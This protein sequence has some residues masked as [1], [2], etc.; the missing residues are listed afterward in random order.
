MKRATTMAEQAT[1][2]ATTGGGYAIAGFVYQLVNSLDYATDVYVRSSASKEGEAEA[3]TVTLEPADG[4]DAIHVGAAGKATIQFKTRR[5][6]KFTERDVLVEVLPDLFKA[7]KSDPDQDFVLQTNASVTLSGSFNRLCSLLRDDPIDEALDRAD[8][9]GLTFKAHQAKGKRPARAHLDWLLSVVSPRS[10]TADDRQALAALLARF[11]VIAGVDETAVRKRV[12]ARLRQLAKSDEEAHVL[13]KTLMGHLLNLAPSGR[14]VTVAE[15]FAA[16]RIETTDLVTTVQFVARVH[17]EFER[18]ME[19]LGYDPAHESRSNPLVAFEPHVSA[20]AGASG[21]GKTW[22]L[23]RAAVEADADGALVLWIDRPPNE[24]G[25]LQAEV[26]RRVQAARRRTMDANPLAMRAILEQAAGTGPAL[27]LCVCLDRFSSPQS[28]YELV[29]DPWL[30]DNGIE[31]IAALPAADPGAI[32]FE[33]D[34]QVVEVEPFTLTEVRRYLKQQG[35]VWTSIPVDVLRLLRTPA[36]ARQFASLDA[37]T[38][39]PSDEYVLM[40]SAWRRE[41]TGP[42]QLLRTAKAILERRIDLMVDRILK[43]EA[44][45][46]PWPA[47]AEPALAEPQIEA[48]ER[49]GFVRWTTDG[50]LQFDTD[51]VLAWGLAEALARRVKAGSVSTDE[52]E[53]LMQRWWRGEDPSAGLARHATGYAPLDLLWLLAADGASPRLMDLIKTLTPGRRALDWSDIATLGA[54]G[55]AIAAAYVQTVAPKNWPPILKPL[56]DALL[57]GDGANSEVR[58]IATRFLR[59]AS[60]EQRMLALE[61]YIRHPDS[62]QLAWLVRHRAT[63]D[64]NLPVAGASFNRDYQEREKTYRAALAATR[65][66]PAAL[67]KIASNSPSASDIRTI[68]WLISELP[69]T[70]AL[71]AWRAV[72]P[73]LTEVVKGKLVADANKHLQVL[74]DPALIAHLAEDHGDDAFLFEAQCAVE[75]DAALARFI[76]ASPAV[77]L[78]WLAHLGVLVRLRPAVVSVLIRCLRDGT[79]SSAELARRMGDWSRSSPRELWEALMA[80]A[81]QDTGRDLWRL[82][83]TM[84]ATTSAALVDALARMRDTP[85]ERQLVVKGRQHVRAHVGRSADFDLKAVSA[86]LL[87]VGGKGFASLTAARLAAA[88]DIEQRQ[89]VIDA[90]ACDDPRV[91][92]AL[93]EGLAAQFDSEK[94]DQLSITALE[95]LALTAPRQ[96]SRLAAAWLATDQVAGIWAAGEIAIDL[97]NPRLAK[98]VLARLG[99][100]RGSTNRRLEIRLLVLFRSDDARLRKTIKATL[101]EDGSEGRALAHWAGEVLDDLAM[102]ERI[103][104]ALGEDL[105]R[106]DYR[107]AD[108]IS[109]LSHHEIIGPRLLARLRAQPR[110]RGLNRILSDVQVSPTWA[111]DGLFA[112]MALDDALQFRNTFLNTPRDGQNRLWR[113]DP[114]IGFEVFEQG[115]VLGGRASEGLSSPAVRTDPLR[116]IP[117]LLRFVGTGGN[118]KVQADMGRALRLAAQT[119]DLEARVLSLLASEEEASRLRGLAAAGWIATPPLRDA[120]LSIRRTDARYDIKRALRDATERAE[121]LADMWDLAVRAGAA[122]GSTRWNLLAILADSDADGVLRPYD[123]PLRLAIGELDERDALILESRLKR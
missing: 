119:T 30:A 108:T 97:K 88:S 4:G 82:I 70:E 64:A 67:L 51:R 81:S 18:A 8:K 72:S 83:R 21:V 109:A 54:R 111:Q 50:G 17:A 78:E 49:V 101:R 19:R 37:P 94:R 99:K 102:L 61:I 36:L 58:R 76:V 95:T 42:V 87:R 89:G 71:A 110:G 44:I 68:A 57:A 122:T 20:L 115:F 84:E 1:G 56:V 53:P 10:Q 34:V 47:E 113:S 77:R 9:E 46:Y 25:A 11:R 22:T 118:D 85:F 86:I 13:Q 114:E 40:E 27:R 48:L 116:A 6:R 55:S 66:F 29:T 91:S 105:S 45:T 14:A 16:C 104:Q 26:A 52:L 80:H 106:A 62:R 23:A 75:P 35:I 90:L 120:M 15:I 41:P 74:A 112:E 59:S 92:R 93:A 65:A 107:D 79:L 63:F 103:E 98:A 5:G 3:V 33:S 73:Q 12:F 28:A 32:V 43:G 60:R 100:R 39:K 121:R 38:F 31:L 117:I 96:A 69:P 123:D 2:R 7:A 24:R